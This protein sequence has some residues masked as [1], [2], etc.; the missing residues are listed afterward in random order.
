M[1]FVGVG[2]PSVE[3]EQ[4]MRRMA[5]DKSGDGHV[6]GDGDDGVEV[7]PAVEAAEAEA[8]G[9]AAAEGEA[10]GIAQIG[11]RTAGSTSTGRIRAA[12][13][14]GRGRKYAPA[15]A[16]TGTGGGGAR[17][18]SGSTPALG[19]RPSSSAAEALGFVKRQLQHRL[20]GSRHWAFHD[21]E[22]DAPEANASVAPKSGVHG[23]PVCA[24]CSAAGL[25]LLRLEKR[26]DVFEK[27]SRFCDPLL[28][29]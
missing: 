20:L 7:A 15:C 24:Y 4:E 10:P 8:A 22:S 13:M 1:D 18:S 23:R 25:S 27:G 16:C 3:F 28:D 11:W 6:D 21:N 29:L 17:W 19:S 12:G 5:V 26:D 2:M 14:A 9:V